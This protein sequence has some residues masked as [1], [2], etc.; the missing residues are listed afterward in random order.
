MLPTPRGHAGAWGEAPLSVERGGLHSCRENQPHHALVRCHL[1]PSQQLFWSDGENSVNSLQL[2]LYGYEGIR[3]NAGDCVDSYLKFLEM[4]S[5]AKL[6]HIAHA[7][8]FFPWS[9]TF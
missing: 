1:V 2:I 4:R 6:C 8:N 5:A 7:R 3:V 9:L